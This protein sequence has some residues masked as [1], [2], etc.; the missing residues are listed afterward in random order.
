MHRTLKNL[1][2]LG[3]D[4]AIGMVT[5]GLRQIEPLM[6]PIYKAIQNRQTRSK[7]L[8]ADETRWKVLAEKSGKKLSLIHI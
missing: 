6:V 4:L 5:D 2:L 8:H 3:L 1:Q 7:Y